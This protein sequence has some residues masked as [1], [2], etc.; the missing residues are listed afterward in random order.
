MP[1]LLVQSQFL[2]THHQIGYQQEQPIK[3]VDFKLI[4]KTQRNLIHINE[5]LKPKLS[6]I[7]EQRD[8][9]FEEEAH[10]LRLSQTVA[11][12]EGKKELKT[13][14]DLGCNFF[15]DAEIDDCS[16]ISVNLGSG[17]YVELR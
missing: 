7:C 3:I 10:Y 17:I 1:L 2:P 5:V 11:K 4:F 9:V 15:C 8:S 13:K 12:L 6:Q 16:L 14:V